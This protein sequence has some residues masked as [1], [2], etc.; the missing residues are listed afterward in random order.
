MTEEN[1]T[2]RS[3]NKDNPGLYCLS[4]QLNQTGLTYCIKNTDQKKCVVF[5]KHSFDNVLLTRVL[6]EKTT[7]VLR[8]DDLLKLE[9]QR[10]NFIVYTRQST[11]VPASLFTEDAASDYLSFTMAGEMDDVVLY[12]FI[13]AFNVYNTFALHRDVCSLFSE[14]FK[15]P[16]FMS[17]C[18]A[19]LKYVGEQ[20]NPHLPG[21]VYLGINAEFIDIGVISKGRL[22]YYNTFQYANENDLLYYVTYVYRHH[23][24]DP[25]IIPLIISGEKGGK[26]T[27]QEVLKTYF[28]LARTDETAGARFIAPGLGMQKTSKYINLLNSDC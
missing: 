24:L 25:A 10:V 6:I 5:R 15:K 27:Y 13:K 1:L 12:N 22:L 28:P 16:E 8:E 21:T 11:L 23:Q 18:T 2:D 17:Q 7:R 14:H 26:I 4:L 9:F 3:F 20:T 19:F